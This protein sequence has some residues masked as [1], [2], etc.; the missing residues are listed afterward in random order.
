MVLSVAQRLKLSPREIL[1]VGDRL[2]DVLCAKNVDAEGVLALTG[3][4]KSELD[5]AKLLYPNLLTIDRFDEILS[6][7]L[8]SEFK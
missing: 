1:V 6:L 4:G 5:E 8:L 3:K 7:L 2:S